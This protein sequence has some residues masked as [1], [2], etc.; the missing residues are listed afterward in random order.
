MTDPFEF[1]NRNSKWIKI[2]TG[3][4]FQGVYLGCEPG[5]KFKGQDSLNYKFAGDKT[6]SSGSKRLA[7]KMRNI[8]E[9]TNIIIKKF[10][11][12]MDTVYEVEIVGNKQ[13]I[14]DLTNQAQKEW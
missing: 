13:K 9:G 5:E 14:D 11:A 2:P 6:L 7:F 12:G 3:G 10:G 1:L 4:S 8:I